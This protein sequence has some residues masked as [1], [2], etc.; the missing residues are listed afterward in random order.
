MHTFA[1]TQAFMLWLMRIDMEST[2]ARSREI[3]MQGTTALK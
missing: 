3:W 1:F 2:M